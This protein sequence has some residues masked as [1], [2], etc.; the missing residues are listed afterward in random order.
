VSRDSVLLRSLRRVETG[1]TDAWIRDCCVNWLC[2][3]SVI[4]AKYPAKPLDPPGHDSD[5]D[6][7]AAK[8][9]SHRPIV[10]T[11][12]NDQQLSAGDETG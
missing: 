7:P 5:E 3:G 10:V 12:R 11:H 9:N 6:L 1:L 4:E 2:S 8:G